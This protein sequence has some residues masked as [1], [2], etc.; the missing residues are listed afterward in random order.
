MD[1]RGQLAMVALVLNETCTYVCTSSRVVNSS[2]R[3]LLKFV[4][5]NFKADE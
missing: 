3:I 4:K 1:I 5:E 2:R